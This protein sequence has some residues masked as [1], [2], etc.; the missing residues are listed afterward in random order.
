MYVFVCVRFTCSVLAFHQVLL[1]RSLANANSRLRLLIG[2]FAI[3]IKLKHR[4]CARPECWV[5]RTPSSPM[6][7]NPA[8]VHTS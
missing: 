4:I 2:Q 7:I 5:Y 3:K 6:Q 1:L 8:Y